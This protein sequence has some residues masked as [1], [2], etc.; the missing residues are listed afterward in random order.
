[1]KPVVMLFCGGAAA[2]LVGAALFAVGKYN[3]L[4]RAR[5][6]LV[7]ETLVLDF[8]VRRT[9][10]LLVACEPSA[11]VP[12]AELMSIEASTLL[13]AANPLAAG[14][15]ALVLESATRLKTL[16]EQSGR[17]EKISADLVERMA[18]CS[19]S[20]LA[21]DALFRNGISA[22]VACMCGFSPVR[23]SASNSAEYGLSLPKLDIRSSKIGSKHHTSDLGH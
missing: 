16:V 15:A 12:Q 22:G 23:L 21:Y 13:G 6:R 18:A 10:H 3:A 2:G 20:V 8:L 14:G 17:P 4:V 1:M 9:V 11:S 19:G 5:S 7:T